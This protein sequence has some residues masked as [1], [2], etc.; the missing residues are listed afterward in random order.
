M[1]STTLM[2]RRPDRGGRGPSA[3][4][5]S[6]DEYLQAPIAQRPASLELQSGTLRLPLGLEPVEEAGQAALE[7]RVEPHV[8]VGRLADPG[9]R[10]EA[11]H[12][13]VLRL[14]AEDVVRGAGA[15]PGDGAPAAPAR[16]PPRHEAR[17]ARHSPGR[18]RARSASPARGD[19]GLIA[20][21][22]VGYRCAS[23]PPRRC[24]T[25]SR[26]PWPP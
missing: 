19:R 12:P 5:S 6:V 3:G 2:A 24:V 23:P 11:A 22:L 15:P 10:R 21:R 1:S 18:V 7:E 8:H 20:R 13:G 17:D 25:R 9:E 26:A 14:R 4:R 16:E